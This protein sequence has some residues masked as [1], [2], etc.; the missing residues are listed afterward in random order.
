M[1]IK[2]LH[3]NRFLFERQ[4]DCVKDEKFMELYVEQ[5]QL[6]ENPNSEKMLS[7]FHQRW[8]LMKSPIKNLSQ[9]WSKTMGLIFNYY[10]NINIS[11]YSIMDI[12]TS[13]VG[14]E[15]ILLININDD[16]LSKL[17]DNKIND[18]LN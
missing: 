2:F 18:I 11:H 7:N 15:V 6:Q 10:F 3:K 8:P 12:K 13:M 4:I 1:I 14:T 5:N 17:R 9:P 16:D